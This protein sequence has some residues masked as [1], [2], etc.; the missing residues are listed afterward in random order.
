MMKG[1]EIGGACALHVACIVICTGPAMHARAEEVT[2]DEALA[3]GARSPGVQGLENALEARESADEGMRGAVGPTAL[4]LMPGALV[5]PKQA[6][7]FELQMTLTQ[8][9][10]LGGLGDAR[11]E[12]ASWERQ[13]VAAS[14][15]ARALRARLEAARRWIDLATLTLIQQTVEER[16]RNAEE[17]VS[18]RERA[19]AAEVGTV[20]GLAEARAALA[21]LEEKRLALE[22]DE[23]NASTQLA[24]AMGQAPRAERLQAVGEL[25]R[26]PM[27][28]EAEIRN[29]I[30]DIDGAPDVV[31]EQLRETAAR[32]RAAEASALYAPI[33]NL[34]TQ[35]ERAA[36]GD[37][38]AWIVFGI[39][40]VSFPG[41]AQKQRSVSLAD[42]QVATAA[43]ST[44]NA[45]L[46]VRA[47]LEEA[48]HE[49]EH[50]AAVAALLEKKTLP[51]LRALVASRERA[52]EVGEETAFAL[53]EARG[54]ELA[55]LE[56]TH[57]AAGANSWARVHMWLLLA[58][59]ASA[60]SAP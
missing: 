10:S 7:A 41:L 12:A 6:D 18:Q 16:I 32:A 2:F 30:A 3:L 52:V 39:A 47:E 53:A 35:V 46:E 25:P 31:V 54:Q 55:A 27:P 33:L 20:H 24:V 28:V 5:S 15:R 29:R 38:G 1:K 9:W 34:G 58:E 22:G 8:G 19:L 40:G 42:E 21:A 26:P 17:L 13:A 36:V 43:A 37:R 14:V 57:R 23:F 49:L 51:A 11:R 45:R 50:T 48:L 44:T 59:L 4:T 56:A 60:G